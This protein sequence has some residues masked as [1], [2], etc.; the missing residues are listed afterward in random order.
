M[1]QRLTWGVARAQGVCHV[2]VGAT[3]ELEKYIPRLRTRIAHQAMHVE[4]L[5]DYPHIAKRAREIL[6][7]EMEDL[8]RALIQVE[9]LRKQAAKEAARRARDRDDSNVA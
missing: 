9:Q 2:G 5:A 8:R 1:E 4:G 6:A 3:G 7:Q